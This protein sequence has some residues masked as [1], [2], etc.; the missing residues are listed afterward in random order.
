M[1]AQ[2]ALVVSMF[3]LAFARVYQGMHSYD[4]VAFGLTLG[5]A[6]ALSL[7]YKIKPLIL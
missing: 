7:H 6:L 2:V 4:Q 5:L 3:T 1:G